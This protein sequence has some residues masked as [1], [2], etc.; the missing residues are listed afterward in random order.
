MPPELVPAPLEAGFRFSSYGPP[1]NPGPA[2]W[3]SVG[4]QM[5]GKFSSARPA[6]IWIVG[7]FDGQGVFL[8]F[9]CTT[10]DPYIHCIAADINEAALTLFDQ[11]G[12]AVWLQVEPGAGSVDAL[13][14]I[15]LNQ[16]KH[17]PCVVGFGID[18]EWYQSDGTPEGKPITD[19]EAVRWV[20]A[21]QSHNPGYLLFLKHWETEWM[22]PTVRDGIFFVDDSQQFEDF[23]HLQREFVEWGQAFAPAQVG[24]QYGYPADKSWWSGLADPP[25]DIGRYLV[26]HIPNTRG[27]FWVDFTVLEVFPPE[28]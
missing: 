8:N 15:T 17:H 19:Q 7:I 10:D 6:A 9:P 1:H 25:G 11:Q 4:Q 24:F 23:K 5:A 26:E 22:P 27:L 12:F 2:Y 3:A 16:Y 21:V 28:P 13:I 20:K 14:D 18:V